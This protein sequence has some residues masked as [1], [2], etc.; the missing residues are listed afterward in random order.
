[1]RVFPIVE[2]VEP[3]GDRVVVAAREVAALDGD[4]L[5]D[6]RIVK[7]PAIVAHAAVASPRHLD[8]VAIVG[9][10]ERGLQRRAGGT[11]VVARS[12]ARSAHRHIAHRDGCRNLVGTQFD[13][14]A[15]RA[16][17]AIAVA[18]AEI[19]GPNS[20]GK[21]DAFEMIAVIAESGVA[22]ELCG[23][24]DAASVAAA[25][26]GLGGRVKERAVEGD[27]SGLAT[28]AVLGKERRAT[29]IESDDGVVEGQAAFTQRKDGAAAAVA[30]DGE[31]GQR[32][33]ATAAQPRQEAA[34]THA[35]VA[36]QEQPAQRDGRGVLVVEQDA[37]TIAIA[38]AAGANQHGIGVW[39]LGAVGGEQVVLDGGRTVVDVGPSPRARGVA[40]D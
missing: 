38:H 22:H 24:N 39:L 27:G 26:F 29:C 20:I 25:G 1:M 4:A 36:A 17:V 21:G 37:T 6:E 3:V 16:R 28:A 14:A 18:E 9:G 40:V 30:V 15:N 10:V 32:Q 2:G 5:G 11:V 33:G 31:M 35:F 23:R 19:V 34:A 8:Q 13:I 12:A 7:P